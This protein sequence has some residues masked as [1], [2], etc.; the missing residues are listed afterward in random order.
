M[1]LVPAFKVD[2]RLPASLSLVKRRK[3]DGRGGGEG[4][5]VTQRQAAGKVRASVFVCCHTGLDAAE[6]KGLWVMGSD[7]GRL[8]RERV[9]LRHGGG[10]S[11][12]YRVTSACEKIEE[13]KEALH[14]K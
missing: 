4:G 5:S 10:G 2:M 13:M 14:F 1:F 3:R 7:G 6:K 8:Q 11:L 12:E 9:S